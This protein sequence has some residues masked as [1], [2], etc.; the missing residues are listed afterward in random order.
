MIFT[1]ALTPRVEISPAV[2]VGGGGPLLLVAGPCV[3]EDRALCLEVA[4]ATA[5]ICRRL[6]IPYVF[7]ASF[8][9]ANRTSG[10]S[11]RGTGLHRGL[12]ILG[13]VRQ[14]VGIPVLTDVHEVV[15]VA[16]AAEVVDIL[17]VP[18]FLCRQTDL[19]VAVGASGRGVNLKKGQFMAP[20]DMAYALQKVKSGGD[21]P[22][23]LTE[24]GTSFG[25][26]DLVVDPRSF[27]WLAELG[28]PVLFDGTHSVQIP[29]GAG[30]ATSGQREMIPVLCRAAVAAG[31]DGLF[32][33][34]HPHPARAHSD[35]ATQLA[36]TEL[37]PLLRSLLPIHAVV[38][39]PIRTSAPPG[40]HS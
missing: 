36:L 22:V 2:W 17:Q 37:E 21:V 39:E 35:A 26:R 33:E 12:Q 9:K 34:V 3:I 27:Q 32:L 40:E 8:D 11:R 23:V 13:E 18:A 19:L 1:P 28:A 29:G 4:A 14:G 7:K 30:G 6:G 15:Q 31:V 25:Y 16:P 38:K 20:G 5:E 10:H 24:R